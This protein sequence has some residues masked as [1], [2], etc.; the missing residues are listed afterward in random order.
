MQFNAVPPTSH[1]LQFSNC[2]HTHLSG[3]RLRSG[4]APETAVEVHARH[5]ELDALLNVY[6]TA[7]PQS[8]E[9]RQRRNGAEREARI[10]LVP[11][12]TCH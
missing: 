4:T 8:P 11:L 9:Q 6:G 12:I 3:V 10:D 2:A 1:P 7:V 5:D